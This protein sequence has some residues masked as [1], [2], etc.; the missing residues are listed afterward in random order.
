M[1]RFTL[2]SVLLLSLQT[3]AAKPSAASSEEVNAFSLLA[4][5]R[6]VDEEGTPQ[7]RGSGM[8]DDSL[9][10]QHDPDLP[11]NRPIVIELAEPFDLSRLEVINSKDEEDYP[12]I[13]VKTL[14]VE[15][16]PSPKGP[17]TPLAEL[18]VQRGQK[19]QTQAVS[20][21]KARY[22][23]VTLVDNHGNK[24][25]IGLSEL[26][27]WGKRSATRPI[28][29]TGAWMTNYGEI[30]LTQTGQRI[31]GCYGDEGSQAGNKTVEGT[32]EG[33]IFF[34]LWREAGT[35]GD[36]TGAMAF[37]L[38]LEGELSGV[39]GSDPS[40]KNR[41]ARWDGT[42]LAKATITCAK[43]EAELGQELKEQGRVVLRGILFDTGKDTIRSE[44]LPVLEALA[45]AMKETPEARYLIEGHTDDRGGEAPNQKLSEKRAASVKKWLVGKGIPAARLQTQGFGMSRP[46]LPND[47]EAGRAA[48]RRVE[49]VRAEQ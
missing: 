2:V 4:G 12:G 49:V 17:W 22:F 18:S 5:A 33:P 27:A 46:T 25:W 48:N 10:G 28:H 41:S 40:G 3:Q 8:F 13:S 44:S 42:K 47:S 7:D 20:A 11:S 38:T 9:E 1:S 21:K 23:R 24:E 36:V 45:G 19:P 26:R 31:T 32:L 14:R 16:G 39:W 43:P 34:G 37:A 35:S 6:P 30:R 29:F 15:Q